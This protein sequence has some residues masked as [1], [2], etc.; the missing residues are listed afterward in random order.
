MRK[1]PCRPGLSARA[2]SELVRWLPIIVEVCA[3]CGSPSRP[4]GL[5]RPAQGLPP[6]VLR[7]AKRARRDRSAQALDRTGF[8]LRGRPSGTSRPGQHDQGEKRSSHRRGRRPSPRRRRQN[9]GCGAPPD[10]RLRPSRPA[11]CKATICSGL[12]PWRAAGHGISP[13]ERI[14][15]QLKVPVAARCRFRSSRSGEPLR[16]RSLRQLGPRRVGRCG[17][18]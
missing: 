1:A 5:N 8:S 4:T 10:R 16:R 9:C 12:R 17:P 6:P 14:A 13:I 15:Q 11:P 7:L 3:S 2:R 18:I